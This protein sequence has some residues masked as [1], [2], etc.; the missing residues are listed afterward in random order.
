MSFFW[1]LVINLF[2]IILYFFYLFVFLSP[3]FC[4]GGLG[5]IFVCDLVSYGLILLSLS[6]C[7]LTVLARESV[8]RLG[9]APVILNLGT[10]WRWVGNFTHRPLFSGF[11]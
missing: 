6:I 8:F 7:V 10:R 11:C 3:F 2:F 9:I 4:W 5:Y 1:V